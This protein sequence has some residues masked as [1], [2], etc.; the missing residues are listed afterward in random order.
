MNETHYKAITRQYRPQVFA[1]VFGQGPLI[2]TL[3]NALKN[4]KVSHA[5][6]FS[7]TRGTGKTTLARLLAKALNCESLTKNFE[8]CNTCT[9]CREI[10][11]GH[12][13]DVI[14]ID[15]ASHRGIDDVRK[16]N[17]TISF[18]PSGRYKIYIIDEVHMLTKEAFN[19]L[20]KTLEEPPSNVKFFFATT[21][22]H[23]VPATIISRC[24]RFNLR[25]ITESDIVDKLEKI[26]SSLQGEAEAGA[27]HLIAHLAE[28]SLRDA[29]S[30]LDQVLSFNSGVLTLHA[31]QEI[32]GVPKRDVYY[33]LDQAGRKGH[34]FCAYEIA[35]DLYASGKNYSQ[36]LDGLIEHFR[37]ILH[38]L[39]APSR[40]ALPPSLT[41]QDIA[42]YKE[43]E[44]IYRQEQVL[45]I[46][47]HL[48]QTQKDL[49]TSP[50][51]QVTV[52]MALLYVIRSHTHLPLEAIINKIEGLEKKIAKGASSPPSIEQNAPTPL[53][54]KQTPTTKTP[55]PPKQTSMQEKP[56]EE[57]K[58]A[59]K[60]LDI[61]T[62]SRHDT[63]MRFAAVEWDG[64]LKKT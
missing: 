7:G 37:V 20:L 29:E 46:L 47:E 56:R 21:E 17:E 50:S 27:L 30:L 43:A 36:F 9:S 25:R 32:L 61:K 1:D 35:E 19:A 59:A 12:S 4:D 45:D 26:V 10:T 54:P 14:E 51:P 42:A 49:R 24:Q 8:P 15:G 60:Q 18:S 3:K 23:K 48:L 64:M 57:K 41:E 6:L 52:E 31:A 28:G 22:S 58:L 53:P 39:S 62:K 55:P 16:I 11:S 44:N 5:Y 38:L 13:L 33:K 40:P 34:I 2:T 63:L